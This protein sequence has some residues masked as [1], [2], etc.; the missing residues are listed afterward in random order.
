MRDLWA[1]SFKT[2]KDD[3]MIAA[4]S[5]FAVLGLLVIYD[6]DYRRGD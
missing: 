1:A 6:G 4:I 3:D 5:I 2:R